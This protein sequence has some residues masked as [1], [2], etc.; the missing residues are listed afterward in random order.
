MRFASLLVVT[1]ALSL[2]GCTSFNAHVEPG[3]DLQ[4]YQRFFV[5]SNLDDNQ[6]IGA[7]LVRALQARGREAELGPLTMLPTSAQ[8]LVTF[9]DRWTWDFRN[10]MVALRIV[11]LDARSRQPIAAASFTGPTALTIDAPDVVERLV[12]DL[13]AAPASAARRQ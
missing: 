1:L 11:V 5:Q 9:Q 12:T 6:G 7:M 13:F 4:S 10:H 8:V 2:A 3:R